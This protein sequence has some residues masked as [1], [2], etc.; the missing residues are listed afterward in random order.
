MRLPPVLDSVVLPTAVLRAAVLDGE[1]YAV[2]DGFRMIDL[3]LDPASRACSLRTLAV[4]GRVI[5]DRSAAWVWGVILDLALPW[6]AIIA[7]TAAVGHSL[8]VP[9]LGVRSRVA[10]LRTTDVCLPGGIAVTSPW[11]TAIDLL[12]AD[13][14]EVDDNVIIQL[15]ELAGA[16]ASEIGAD[17][18]TRTRM[19]G[20]KRG[21]KRLQVLVTR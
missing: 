20:R 1:V 17:L 5:A 15:I 10:R 18:A 19:R 7:P 12:C 8:G 13:G 11:R 21:L 6:S 2:G 9:E 16:S 4:Q 3:P 14:E